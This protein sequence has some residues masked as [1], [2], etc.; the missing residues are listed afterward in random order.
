MAYTFSNKYLL[1]VVPTFNTV[2]NSGLNSN[3]SILATNISNISQI[4]DYPTQSIS[5]TTL[6]P[7]NTQTPV[8]VAGS[9]TIN[10]ILEVGKTQGGGTCFQVDGDTFM[11]GSLTVN[12]NVSV[13]G[14][15]SATSFITTSDKRYK[16]D[17]E[18]LSNALSTLC[19]L[20]GI[21]YTL[22]NTLNQK[23]LGFLAQD[24][25]EVVPQAVDKSDPSKWGV[26]YTQI[27]PLLVEAIKELW[28]SRLSNS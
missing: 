24:V 26:E 14:S 13:Q 9:M 2:Q 3:T 27:I 23:K 4:V 28:N 11:D 18:P 5:I 20:Q 19:A 8:I 7:Y 17:I 10:G 16:T 12:S 15:V 6:Y 1:N 21:Y 22:N 25:D